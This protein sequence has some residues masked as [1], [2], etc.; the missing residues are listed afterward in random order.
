MKQ[1]TCV[2]G[3]QDTF[4]NGRLTENVHSLTLTLTSALTLFD[5]TFSIKQNDVIFRASFQIRSPRYVRERQLLDRSF[6]K[7]CKIH[8]E[9]VGWE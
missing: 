9:S 7:W 2:C 5:K 8:L 1:P 4:P 3:V 6:I